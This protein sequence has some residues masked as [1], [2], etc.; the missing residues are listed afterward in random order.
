MIIAIDGHMLGD[1]SGGNESHYTNILRAMKPDKEDTVYLFVKSGAD[2]SEFEEKFRI[3]RFASES[4][5]RRNFTELDRLCRQYKVQVL[6]TQY[7]IPFIRSCRTVCTIHDICFEHY[8][9]IFTKTEYC[10]QKLLIPYAAKHSEYIFTVSEHAKADIVEHYHVDPA[11]VIVTYNAVSEDFRVL[12]REELDEAEL[13]E[14]FAIGSAPFVLSVG[15][16]Q[17]RKNLPRL[18]EAFNQWKA[19]SSSPARLVIVGKKAWMYSEILKSAGSASGNI[20]LT[21][22]VSNEDLV[23]LYNAAESFVF[24]SYFEGFGIPPLEVLALGTP[25][26]VVTE[27]TLQGL[28]GRRIGLV[29]TPQ[30]TV[31]VP[32]EGC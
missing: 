27:K 2:V 5:F 14:R 15:N 25:E 28:Y 1:R 16:L 11:R 24:P 10:R 17:P 12:S 26:E 8:K 20:V 31:L 7:F 18:I 4:P 30:G 6:H 19:E 13:R 29:R 21:D 23:R 22:Y 3:V 32:E 9:N